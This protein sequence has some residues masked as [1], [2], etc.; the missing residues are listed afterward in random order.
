MS[1]VLI[2]IGD[3]YTQGQG[4]IKLDSNTY[5]KYGDEVFNNAHR[6]PIDSQE[7]E[8]S[9]VNQVCTEEL[10]LDYTPINFGRR[11]G[12]NRSSA[13]E[14]YLRSEEIPKDAEDII[15]VY[16]LSAMERFDFV[17]RGE[18]INKNHFYTGFRFRP[19]QALESKTPLYDTYLNH[20]FS[21]QLSV[22][23]TIMNICEVET[24]CK[25]N[26]AKLVVTSAFDHMITK[27]YFIRN[28][29]DNKL[30][31]AD[32]VD[33]DNFFRPDGYDTMLH[34]LLSYQEETLLDIEQGLIETQY[35]L[36]VGVE[37]YTPSYFIQLKDYWNTFPCKEFLAPCCHPTYKG[38]TIIAETLFNEMK[39]RKYV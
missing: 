12:G 5:K 29:P 11:G 14:L 6:L 24:W 10:L 31:L 27:D 20:I 8:G 4:S 7:R 3:S 38:Y 39:K 30:H 25:A 17:E 1:K 34:M 2:G 15:V 28:L 9:W 21:E 35:G 26:N 32:L 18:E 19:K 23:E 16:M 37:N 22:V 36:G 13:K 33:W